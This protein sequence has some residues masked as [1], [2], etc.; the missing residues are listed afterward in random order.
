M[1]VTGAG[2]KMLENIH[3]DQHAQHF[4]AG[5]ELRGRLPTSAVLN[6]GRRLRLALKWLKSFALRVALPNPD[7]R[8]FLVMANVFTAP[9]PFQFPPFQFLFVNIN[10]LF[11]MEIKITSLKCP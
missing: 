11:F 2:S 1:F 8:A 9:V 5:A 4:V 10:I 3:K 6:H 7:G